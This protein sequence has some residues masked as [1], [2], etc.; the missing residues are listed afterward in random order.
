MLYSFQNNYVVGL[1]VYR[2]GH[3]SMIEQSEI[4]TAE[5]NRRDILLYPER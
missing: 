1:Y 5:C 2:A 3:L 4:F